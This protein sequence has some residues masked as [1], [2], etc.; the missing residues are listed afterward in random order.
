MFLLTEPFVISYY[1]LNDSLWFHRIK[2]KVSLIYVRL[3]DSVL[4]QHN[5]H[6][7][8]TDNTRKNNNNNRRKRA[9][10]N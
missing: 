10:K 1:Y 2:S 3:L 7:L 9:Y 8:T 6:M 4:Q 5:V